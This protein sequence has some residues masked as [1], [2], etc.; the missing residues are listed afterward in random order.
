MKG[1]LIVIE[2]ND[3]SGKKTQSDLL[4]KNLKDL[5][6]KVEKT[7]FPQY[8]TSFYGKLIAKYLNGE[9][10]S[11]KTISPYLSSLLY[12]C[13][14]QEA[15]DK[16]DAFLRD[17]KIVVSNRYVS[18]NA[19]YG[20]ARL[21]DE[22]KKIFLEWLNE[23]EYIKNGLPKPD[24][25]IYLHVTLDI[26]ME[27]IKTKE[28]REYLEGKKKDIHEKSTDYLRK[29]EEM[30]LSLSQE[31]GWK[32]IDCTDGNNILSIEEISAEIMKRVKPFI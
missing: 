30:Y 29:V 15:K 16:L 10:G 9:F 14:R 18:S 32:K 26:A 21:P 24:L 6:Y 2:G 17:G 3:S 8:Y 23:L 12:A 31:E 5:G 7:D 27:W 11:I 13:D 28:K 19:A 22:D 1:K 4:V 25:V 20:A